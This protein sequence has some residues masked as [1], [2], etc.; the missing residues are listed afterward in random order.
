MTIEHSFGSGVGA[1]MQLSEAEA[2]SLFVSFDGEN[3]SV[4]D[5]KSGE[6][7]ALLEGDFLVDGSKAWLVV[8]PKDS[9]ESS[10]LDTS[11][12]IAIDQTLSVEE[13]YDIS[14]V[15]E[16]LGFDVERARFGAVMFHSV[17]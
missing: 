8:G 9:F 1:V 12:A 14:K 2:H 17:F 7:F 3:G 15:I 16:E 13:K 6:I 4:F 5:G 10:G 11:Y